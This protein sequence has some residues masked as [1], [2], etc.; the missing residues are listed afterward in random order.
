MEQTIEKVSDEELRITTT[1]SETETIK[2]SSLMAQKE[3][4]DALLDKFK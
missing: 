2:K 1:Y 4:V 3:K